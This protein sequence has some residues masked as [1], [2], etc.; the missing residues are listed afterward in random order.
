MAAD[1][2]ADDDPHVECLGTAALKAGSPSFESVPSSGRPGR[3]A[4][5]S[6]IDRRNR[7]QPRRARP[8]EY[9]SPASRL[10]RFPHPSDGVV[11]REGRTVLTP[12]CYL[13]LAL[14]SRRAASQHR[15][16]VADSCRATT[17]RAD[18]NGQPADAFSAARL[19]IRVNPEE[20]SHPPKGAPPDYV[21][22]VIGARS[23]FRDTHNRSAARLMVAAAA[24]R[25]GASP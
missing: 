20:G 9:R 15:H 25:Q 10:G 6:P 8:A 19:A 18:P 21:W 23:D 14:W 7:P 1:D 4:P 13:S 2:C 24:R 5:R 17:R 16:A 22:W 11:G 3:T 12:A